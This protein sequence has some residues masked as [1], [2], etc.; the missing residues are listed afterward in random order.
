MDKVLNIVLD[1]ICQ[2]N[3]DLKTALHGFTTESDEDFCWQNITDF[4]LAHKLS[5]PHAEFPQALMSSCDEW[6]DC[7]RL[8]AL[9]SVIC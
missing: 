4:T 3:D 8:D 9:G 5:S 7:S 6:S 1:F 2:A